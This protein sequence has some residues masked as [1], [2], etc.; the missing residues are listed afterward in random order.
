[1]PLLEAAVSI[2]QDEYPELDIQQVLG[3]ID[4]LL[5]RLKRRLAPDATPVQRLRLLNHFFFRELSFGGNVNNYYDPDNSYIHV[6]LRTRRGIP[7][8]LALVWMELAQ[9]LGLPAT[10]VSFPGHFM[11]KVALAKGQVVID[12]FTG[13]SLSREELAERLQPFQNRGRVGQADS[14]LPLALFLR[15]AAPRDILTRMLGNLKEIHQQQN[16]WTRLVA[17]LDRMVILQ[18]EH[19]ASWRDRGLARAELGHHRLA[20]ADLERYLVHEP[21]ADDAESV[22]IRLQSLRR[23]N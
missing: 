16:D 20:L 10:G 12:P 21:H 9:G 22:A 11:V 14:E 2:A 6:V 19:W 18:P 23:I 7:I 8:T 13:Q 3:D 4:Q 1:M 17:V 15:S 5:A